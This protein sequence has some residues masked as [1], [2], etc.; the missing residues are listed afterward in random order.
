MGCASSAP[1]KYEQTFSQTIVILRHSERLDHVDKNYKSTPH[2]QLW[3]FDTPLTDKGIQLAKD[4][5][6]ELVAVHKRA[7]FTCVVSSPYHRCMQTAAE[8]AK[9]FKLPLIIDQEVGEVWEEEMP[10]DAP[11]HRKPMQL[12][13][14]AKELGVEVKNPLLPEG[15][16]KLFGKPPAKHAE[17]LEEGHKRCTVRVQYYI[18]QSS[19]T[20]QNFIICS[21]APG[22]AALADIFTRGSL[23]VNALEYCAHVIADRRSKT[24][25][26]NVYQDQWDVEA[27]GVS[28]ELNIDATEEGHVKACEVITD[29]VQNRN[30]NRTKTDDISDQ[31]LKDLI[32]K[33]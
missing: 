32:A 11:P 19:K 15:G 22:V 9:C 23:D 26:V 13:E 25:G 7:K 24:Q 20:Q 28:F 21:H 3:P 4:T 1:K 30:K 18:E 17:T 8:V 10:S 33:V 27:K 16:F 2:G 31:T 29:G 5:A 6:I 14:M 12:Q